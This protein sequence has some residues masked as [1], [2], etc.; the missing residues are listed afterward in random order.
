M[1]MIKRVK[2]DLSNIVNHLAIGGQAILF[3]LFLHLDS[4]EAM[5]VDFTHGEKRDVREFNE[6][7]HQVLREF[8]DTYRDKFDIKLEIVPQK[9]GVNFTRLL[10]TRHL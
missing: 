3:P 8:Y 9:D 2:D 1:E 4:E 7:V 5:S 6:V 10:V